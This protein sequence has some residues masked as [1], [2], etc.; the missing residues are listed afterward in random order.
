MPLVSVHAL[1]VSFYC[2]NW[3]EFA[4]LATNSVIWIYLVNFAVVLSLS[5]LLLKLV[6]L[7]AIW[8][9]PSDCYFALSTIINVI[10]KSS[11]CVFVGFGS[12]LQASEIKDII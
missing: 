3:Y 9:K 6:V 11:V 2:L 12:Y 8:L 7:A 4:I 1:G 10:L 5:C